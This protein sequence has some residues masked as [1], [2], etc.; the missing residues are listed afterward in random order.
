M[1]VSQGRAER[2]DSG[3]IP[4]EIRRRVHDFSNAVVLAADT[5]SHECFQMGRWRIERNHF[6]Y[7]C[8]DLASD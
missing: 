8:R 6:P 3:K 1:P 7:G 2:R 5:R 4:P